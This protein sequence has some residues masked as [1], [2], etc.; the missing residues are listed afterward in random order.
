[1]SDLSA[2]LTDEL[3]GLEGRW[4][5]YA[6]DIE[7]GA[8]A[9][10]ELNASCD[11]QLVS[12]SI[13]KIFI[14]A[15]VYDAVAN[16][17]LDE[18]EA[19]SDNLR[20][21]VAYSD[22]HATNDLVALLGGGDP[23]A[24]MARVNEYCESI[25]CPNVRMNRL[26]LVEDGT[27]NYVSETDCAR[28]LR[29]IFEGECVSPEYSEKMLSIL[30]DQYWED[31]LNQGVPADTVIAHKTGDLIGICQGDVGIVYGEQGPY[32]VCVMCNDAPDYNGNV[33][34]LGRLSGI[35]YDYMSLRPA[36]APPPEDEMPEA[37]EDEPEE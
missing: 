9:R 16:G 13:V 27:Q 24:G 32:I 6:E 31:Y 23:A 34:I 5:V 4:A 35:V 3:A 30:K 22:N 14:M 10:A 11:G 12:A 17:E 15:A 33:P 2:A 19:L 18:D 20:R 7:T 21:M 25:G 28:L 37:P 26:M 36:Q 1:M 29:M 8:I